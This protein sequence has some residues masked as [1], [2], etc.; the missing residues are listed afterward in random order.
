LILVGGNVGQPFRIDERTAVH[1]P[2]LGNPG[3]Q[4]ASAFVNTSWGSSSV[5]TAISSGSQPQHNT[6]HLPHQPRLVIF[7]FRPLSDLS[8]GWVTLPYRSALS[9]AT[10]PHPPFLYP[11]SVQSPRKHGAI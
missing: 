8:A 9:A 4:A 11:S 2:R 6:T 7:I 10:N 1:T 3:L 5:P